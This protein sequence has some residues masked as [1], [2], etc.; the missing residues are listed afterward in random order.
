[1]GGDFP[2]KPVSI[3]ATIWDGSTYLGHHLR[4]PPQI[5]PLR[6]RIRGPCPPWLRRRSR[7]TLA[8]F[9]KKH[10]SYSYCH[11]RVRY[12]APPPPPER[13]LGP[14]AESFLA[15]GEAKFNYRRRRSKHYGRSTADAVVLV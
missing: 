13:V 5:R 2:S 15:S 12:P 11:D 3:Y 9:R 14:E 7:T 4:R 8:P 1:M 10:L 6:C